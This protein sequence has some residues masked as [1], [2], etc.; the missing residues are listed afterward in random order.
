M[1]FLNPLYNAVAWLLAHIHSVLLAPIFGTNSGASWALAIVLLTVGMR[2]VLFPVLL[3]PK[4]RMMPPFCVPVLN[5][6]SSL[7]V[8]GPAI[9]ALASVT[10]RAALFCA[11]AVIAS[12]LLVP[13]LALKD[14]S[15]SDTLALDA[16]INIRYERQVSSVIQ[17]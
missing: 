12:L 6:I 2:L 11:L 3:S 5:H 17:D 16:P 14:E 7:N 13:I 1:S 4:L 8:F 9:G 10:G 15:G